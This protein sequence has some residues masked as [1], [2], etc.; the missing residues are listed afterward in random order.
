M[1]TIIKL[2]AVLL[3]TGC[4]LILIGNSGPV[5]NLHKEDIHADKHIYRKYD[6]YID[7]VRSVDPTDSLVLP[8]DGSNYPLNPSPKQF[9]K[10]LASCVHDKEMFT[11]VGYLKYMEGE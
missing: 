4:A 2:I 3:I 8:I 10:Y 11:M 9:A 6:R 5:I 7:A 1:N